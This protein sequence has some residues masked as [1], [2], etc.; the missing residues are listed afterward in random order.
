[1]KSITYW[2][3]QSFTQITYSGEM[4]ELDPVEVRARP[5]PSRH[6]TPL[7]DI[8]RAILADELGGEAGVERLQ[9]FLRDR[10]L[11]LVVSRNM[12]RRADRQ[13]E[14]NLKV[15]GSATQTAEPGATPVEIAYLQFFEAKAIRG[16]EAFSPGR[17]LLAQPMD[18]GLVPELQGAPRGSVRVGRDGSMAAFL[19]A[20][21]AL[22][23]Q[24]TA[25]N[26]TPVVRERYWVT[27]AR[28][29]MRS[30]ANCHGLN[31]TDVVLGLPAPTN[32]PEALRDLARWYRATYEQGGG[33]PAIS[34]AVGLANPFRVRLD[35]QN[36]DAAA[37]VFIGEDA[38]PWS[39]VRVKG[40][41]RIVLK[42][43]PQLEERFPVGTPVAIRVRN[44]DGR[45][46]TTTFTR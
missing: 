42:K 27:F 33:G 23:W 41:T 20:S 45:E 39:G 29:E 13:Q 10:N 38:A 1:V 6:S 25:P 8:E 28:G 21:R 2:D 4:W 44:G 43:G 9:A 16:Y 15:A 40:T 22:S 37:Q 5:R 34:R 46:A 35:G 18:T 14:Y 26:G 30:C 7:P 31:R 32:P 12:T 3:N 19:P 17:R 36:F 24:L 11:A